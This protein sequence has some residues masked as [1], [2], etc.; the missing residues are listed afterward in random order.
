M[1]LQSIRLSA[2]FCLLTDR[3]A[4]ARTPLH[5]P[6]PYCTGEAH[7]ST[8]LTNGADEACA[9]RWGTARRLGLPQRCFPAGVGGRRNGAAPRNALK[10]DRTVSSRFIVTDQTDA[11]SLSP[12]C[13]PRYTT[14]LQSMH[15]SPNSCAAVPVSKQGCDSHAHSSYRASAHFLSIP[16]T[17]GIASRYFPTMGRFPP[18]SKPPS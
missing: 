4:A 14:S 3:D 8:E 10:R 7:R 18:V 16:S 11:R 2:L 13:L 5:H 1:A 6:K 15:G 12:M 17:A 9:R